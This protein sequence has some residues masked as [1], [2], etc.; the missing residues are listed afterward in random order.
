M[1][2]SATNDD[3]VGK[4]TARLLDKVFRKDKTLKPLRPKV[5]TYGMTNLNGLIGI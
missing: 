3:N 1:E 5:S 2:S 4:V